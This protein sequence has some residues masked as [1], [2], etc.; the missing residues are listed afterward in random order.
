MPTKE[1]IEYYKSFRKQYT[2][3]H[4]CDMLNVLPDTDEQ[5]I[6]E[7]FRVFDHDGTGT[8]PALDFFKALGTV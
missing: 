4:F 1:E 2:F 3:S 8:L 6:I 5:T 7:C